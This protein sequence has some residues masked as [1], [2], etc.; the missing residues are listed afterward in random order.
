MKI[1]FLGSATSWYLADLKRAAGN[2]HTIRAIP[3]SRLASTV[4]ITTAP[5]HAS[6]D[7]L[8]AIDGRDVTPTSLENRVT[9]DF[10][11]RSFAATSDAV[12]L[13]TFDALLVRSMPLG[14]LEQVVFR[15]NV[16]ACCESMGHYIVNPARSLEVAID[17]YLC[18]TQ[19]QAAGFNV[20]PTVVCQT[21]EDA[22]QG[23]ESLGGDV[24]LKPIFGGEG[25]GVARVNDPAIAL[26]A[27]KLLSQNGAVLYLQKFIEHEGFD[28]R[29]LGIGDK[30]LGITRS[31]RE[32]WRTNISLGG[33]A[34][35]L[36]VTD[37][38]AENARRALG[39]TG[40]RMGAVDLLPGRDGKLYAIEVN[41]VPGWRAVSRCLSMDISRLVLDDLV[42]AVASRQR[43]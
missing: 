3:F 9:D 41:A 10:V 21:V 40:V 14:S 42:E 18:L 37:E 2:E 11:D 15:M 16:L 26:H 20:P 19:L 39:A 38:L 1:G 33:H 7:R 35:P 28:F 29:L 25:R 22:M 36:A 32:D 17:K 13:S 24:V 34:E 30:V 31:N 43:P 12:E 27:F 4:G 8:V 23:Y 5:Q 6:Q